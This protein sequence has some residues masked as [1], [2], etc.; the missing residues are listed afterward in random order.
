LKADAKGCAPIN[1]CV[2]AAAAKKVLCGAHGTCS[3]TAPGKYKCVCNSG[4]KRVSV[5]GKTKSGKPRSKCV[6]IHA[7]ESNPCSRYA[8]CTNLPG[9][10]FA[11]KCKAKYA[12]DGRTCT[13][14]PGFKAVTLPNGKHMIVPIQKGD[15][16]DTDLT[17]IEQMLGRLQ[18]DAETP[19]P[20]TQQAAVA[21]SVGATAEP[22]A[23]DRT[24][25]LAVTRRINSLE[26]TTQQMAK[27]ATAETAALMALQAQSK[28][29]NA[30]LM[31]VLESK[32]DGVMD[33]V[34][35]ATHDTLSH[36]KHAEGQHLK[37][38]ASAGPSIG[39]RN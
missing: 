11:C 4:F 20:G 32:A 15:K 8:V 5:S 30:R 24:H 17:V 16:H 34:L 19:V 36:I 37:A 23:D 22:K 3:F 29:E 2:D 38:G 21:A 9:G 18:A 35:D 7:C 1:K 31:K 26:Q 28:A 13:V 27:Q 25:L 12:G 33:T 14:Q 10:K 6:E 39:V